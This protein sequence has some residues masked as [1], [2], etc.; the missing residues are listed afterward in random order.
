V[1]DKGQEGWLSGTGGRHKLWKKKKNNVK[2]KE[3]PDR[4]Q[5]L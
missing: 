3:S 4:R 1:F 2:K 5:N